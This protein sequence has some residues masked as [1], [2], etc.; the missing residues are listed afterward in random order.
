[1]G[2]VFGI[3]AGTYLW[4]PK[5]TGRAVDEYM[6]RLHF[7]TMFIGANLIFFPQHF[8]GLAG[9]TLND[10][11]HFIF[12]SM[13][14]FPLGPHLKPSF[15]TIPVRTYLPKLDRNLIGKENKNR[16][17]IYQ[18]I[19]LI[20]GDTY[21]GSAAKGSSR[22]LSYFL[23]SVLNRNLPIYNSL[24]SYG[25]N[26][27]CLGILEDL[28]YQLKFLNSQEARKTLLEKEQF[29]LDIL[30]LT[31]PSI[32]LN[33]ANV[34]GTTL[35]L[36]HSEQFRLN[37]T[38]KLNPMYGKVFSPEFL[39]MQ[40]K[41]KNGPLNPQYGKVKSMETRAKLQR[42]IYVYDEITMELLGI[43]PTVACSKHFKM[44]KDTLTKYLANSKPFKGKIFS[45]TAL[46]LKK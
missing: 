26:N 20:N 35:G 2:A 7:I 42:L 41:D 21:I 10:H 17:V 34:A 22:L 36:K 44:G 43:F 13:S 24:N 12:S 25:H 14:L 23:P 8:L 18:W 16:P 4:L 1:M 28:T 19:N 32:K 5:V 29:Y 45:Y 6:G 33:L 39:A 31:Y 9:I 15:L 38:G 46:K 40:I 3:F 37:R 11:Y 27:F 30:F